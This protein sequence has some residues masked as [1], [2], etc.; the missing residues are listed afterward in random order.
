M[1]ATPKLRV[2]FFDTFGT[3]VAQRKPVADELWRA[4][5]EALASDT[6]SIDREVRAKATEM[7]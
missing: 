1:V 3:S 7:V 2:L 6:S 5:R 4:A